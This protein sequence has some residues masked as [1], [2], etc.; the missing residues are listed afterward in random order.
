MDVDPGPG[1]DD[2]SLGVVLLLLLYLVPPTSWRVRRKTASHK[3]AA[4]N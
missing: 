3:P 4:I 1:R 2:W